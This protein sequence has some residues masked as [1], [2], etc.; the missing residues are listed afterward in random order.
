MEPSPRDLQAFEAFRARGKFVVPRAVVVADLDTEQATFES[1]AFVLR[2]LEA[3]VEE[4]GDGVSFRAT[5]FKEVAVYVPPSWKPTVYPACYVD[6]TSVDWLSSWAPRPVSKKTGDGD[7]EDIV[8]DAWALWRLGEDSG[9]ALVKIWATTEVECRALAQAVAESLAG[10][11]DSWKGATL[12]LPERALPPPF[13]EAF[14]VEQT[15]SVHLSVRESNGRATPDADSNIW[16]SEVSFAWNATRYTART[17]L[18]DFRPYV[19]I[20]TTESTP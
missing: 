1:F 5:G 3:R 2:E 10:S 4:S 6:G 7:S 16:T 14:P 12:P 13:R 17:R 11:L 15:P 8:T 18:A 20:A 19:K 9:M